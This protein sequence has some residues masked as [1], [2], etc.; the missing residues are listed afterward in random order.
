VT[1]VDIS[2]AALQRATAEGFETVEAAPNKALQVA[3]AKADIVLGVTGVPGAV[4]RLVPP[5]WLR[6]NNPV[7]TVMGYEEF[8]PEFS[9]SEILG[10]QHIPLNY[11]LKHPTLNRYIDATLAAQVL[12]LEELVRYSEHYLPGI[13]PLPEAIDRW[14][15]D[16]W[17]VL[18]PDEDLTGIEEDLGFC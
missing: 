5:A 7:L 11:Y 16:S 8:G 15:L 17:R 4:G 3:L 12:A 13:H 18:W 1:V 6:A 14:L 10:G 9:E 2:T